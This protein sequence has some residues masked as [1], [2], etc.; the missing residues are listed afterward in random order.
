[1]SVAHLAFVAII[2]IACRTLAAPPNPAIVRY[3]P[4]PVPQDAAQ[5]EQQLPESSRT[6]G[7]PD[8]PGYLRNSLASLH[9]LEPL[10]NNTLWSPTDFEERIF[11]QPLHKRAANPLIT[12]PTFFHVVSDPSSANANS[13]NYV[14]DAQMQNQLA[15]LQQAYA[16]LSVSFTLLNTTR[17]TNASWATNSSDPAMKRTLRQ[18]TYG[19]LNVYFQSNLRSDGT[20]GAPSGSVLLGFCTLPSPEVTPQTRP[21]AYVQDGCNVLSSTLPQGSLNNYNLGGTAAHEIG[22]WLG[23][24]HTFQDN[25]CEVG[26]FGDYV[27]D[28]PQQSDATRGCPAQG[29]QDSCPVSGVAEGWSGGVGQGANPYGPQGYSGVDNTRNYMDYS[30]DVCYEGWTAGQGA[31]V[32]NAWNLWRRGR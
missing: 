21:S 4:L 5:F 6:C 28:T 24:L 13:P 29:S 20:D 8:P 25:T 14:T 10:E 15:Y 27:A 7:T 19:S 22:H 23:L 9:A 11:S 18:G 12:I 16:S 17:T 3:F 1:M 30:S 26:N 32:I 31:R 2:S